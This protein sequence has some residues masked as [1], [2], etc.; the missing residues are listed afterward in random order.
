MP[1][2]SVLQITRVM[3]MDQRPVAFMM[4]VVPEDLVDIEQR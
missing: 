3:E 4:D 2:A 1:G